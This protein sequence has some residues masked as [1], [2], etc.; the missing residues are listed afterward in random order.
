VEFTVSLSITLEPVYTILLAIFILN[1]NDVLGS[2]FYLGA[3]I[4]VLVVLANP[5]VK[6]Y[7]KKNG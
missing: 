5:I 7:L 4:I 3:L 6:Y 1:E 2:Q